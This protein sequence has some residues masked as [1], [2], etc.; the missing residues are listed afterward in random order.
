MAGVSLD[1]ARL[2][3]QTFDDLRRNLN[4]MFEASPESYRRRVERATQ[5]VFGKPRK[6]IIPVGRAFTAE[7]VRMRQ[8][9]TED[10][11]DAKKLEHR[12]FPKAP[13]GLPNPAT[14]DRALA[15]TPKS[16]AKVIV[17]TEN[18]QL[19]SAAASASSNRPQVPARP[20]P[21]VRVL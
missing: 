19:A 9:D 16:K 8:P 4:F 14:G 15:A 11:H 13:A 1:L 10:Y 20:T 21:E 12:M 6:H 2:D 18:V 3:Q 7:E 17:T 5:I